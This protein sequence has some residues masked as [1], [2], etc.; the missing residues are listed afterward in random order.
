M[1]LSRNKA[2]AKPSKRFFVRMLTRD[3]SLEDCVLDLVDNSID[4]A[5]DQSGYEPNELV[6][7]SALSKFHINIKFNEHEFSITDNCGG[8]TLDNAAD[9]AFT[10]GRRDDQEP[11]Q[12]SV[13]VYGIGMK[14]AVFKIGEL[15]NIRST[16]LEDSTVQSFRVPI[17]VPEW[18]ARDSA[19]LWN[20]ELPP[21]NWD[22]DIEESRPLPSP[23]VEINIQALRP[24]TAERLGDVTYARTLR[25]ILGRDYMV[26]LMRGLRISVNDVDVLGY[27]LELRQSAEFLP[28]RAKYLDGP[29]AVEIL[30]GMVSMPPDSVDPDESDRRSYDPSGWYILCNGRVVLAA[31]TSAITGWG[32]ELPRWHRQYAGFV[33]VVLFSAAIAA[34]LPMTTTKRSVDISAGVYRRALARMHEPTRSWISYTNV[35]KLDIGT[36]K[37]KEGVANTTDLIDVKVRPAVGLPILATPPPSRVRVGNINYAM[38]YKRIKALAK[39]FGDS[40]TSYRDVGIKSFEYAYESLVSEDE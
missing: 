25:R 6:A 9:Y 36:A 15:I 26:P 11:E 10:F 29:V 33:G 4:G 35:R 34:D 24:E 20:G 2:T 13:G 12:F 5:W 31:D 40:S 19:P 37:A 18:M 22:F 8:I 14:R 3:I 30:A 21:P 28:M 16:Y 39:G 17:N 23:G 7:D 1:V 32:D 27:K 38:P